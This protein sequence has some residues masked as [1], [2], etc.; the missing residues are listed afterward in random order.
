MKQALL[1]PGGP[2]RR[3]EVLLVED[4]GDFGIDVVLE[5]L[6]TNSMIVGGVLT[7]WPDDLG[8]SALSVSV[9]RL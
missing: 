4:V 6:I 1:R 5:E 7:G 9:L 2:S 3:D 8:F